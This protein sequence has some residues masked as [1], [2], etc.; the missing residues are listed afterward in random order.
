MSSSFP[1]HPRLARPPPAYTPDDPRAASIRSCAF[2]DLKSDEKRD[3]SDALDHSHLDEI[4]VRGTVDK[5][6]DLVQA[7]RDGQ[8]EEDDLGFDRALQRPQR[9]FAQHEFDLDDGAI[10]ENE[11]DDD[12]DDNDDLSMQKGNSSSQKPRGYRDRLK[13]VKSQRIVTHRS[14]G[15]SFDTI[16]LASADEISALYYR[17]EYLKLLAKALLHFGAPSHRVESLLRTAA[18]VLD[19][20]AEFLCLPAA[21]I[22]GFGDHD[23]WKVKAD[24][25]KG[26][27]VIV[28]SALHHIHHVYRAVLHDEMSA[29]VGCEELTT[30]INAPPVH[31]IWV[32]DGL[33]F[34]LSALICPLAFGGSFLDLWVAG[35][36]AAVLNHVRASIESPGYIVVFE[37]VITSC[38][39]LHD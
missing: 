12:D 14:C 27:S 36:N 25:V 5:L 22:I 7:F 21:I 29:E 2:D 1:S 4:P 38:W 28:L 10:D 34:V 17:Q 16:V 18:T 13:E 26:D 9:L 37:W 20:T 30:I 35:A 6:Y 15:H 3:D 8:H 32:R 19:L 31:N 23:G 39:V 24:W 11:L 33:A